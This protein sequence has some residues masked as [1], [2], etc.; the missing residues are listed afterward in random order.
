MTVASVKAI[1]VE[2]RMVSSSWWRRN[3]KAGACGRLGR[4]AAF[5]F[6]ASPGWPGI[7]LAHT[8]HGG[9][10]F[11]NAVGD[12]AQT[13]PWRAAN[14]AAAERLDRSRFIRMLATWR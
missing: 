8:G 4:Y 12:L 5:P 7:A 13:S 9:M 11:G 14:A 2:F 1:P 3:Y 10:Y 6:P